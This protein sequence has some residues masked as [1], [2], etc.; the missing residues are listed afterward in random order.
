MDRRRESHRVAGDVV[1]I[2]Y[3]DV[4]GGRAWDKWRDAVPL[5]RVHETLANPDVAF[6]HLTDL[7]HPTMVGAVA[8]WK[9]DSR[10][11]DGTAD[12]I[13][14]SG[15]EIS[16]GRRDE[17]KVLFLDHQADRLF[18]YLHPIAHG[19]TV[20]DLEEHFGDFLD[21]RANGDPRAAS[22]ASFFVGPTVAQSTAEL[23][24]SFRLLWQTYVL[25]QCS[26]PK[27]DDIADSKSLGNPLPFDKNYWT[28]I[29]TADDRLDHLLVEN[30]DSDI[31]DAVRAL[32]HHTDWQKI[33]DHVRTRDEAAILRRLK[34]CV[35]ERT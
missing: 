3:F 11:G 8:R 21:K 16:E 22:A 5:D 30:A 12:L 23:N 20:D 4:I 18:F 7:S 32:A 33:P 26:A 9:K 24:A 15:G 2:A 28:P 25:T 29:L 31:R 27:P 17:A 10:I 6:I 19:A 13:F 34:S 14:L 35:P 1:K